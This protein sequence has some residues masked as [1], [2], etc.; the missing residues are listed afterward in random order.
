M[1]YSLWYDP[2]VHH[3]PKETIVSTPRRGDLSTTSYALLGLLAIQPW[4]TY[5]LAQHMG[6]SVGRLWPRAVSKLYEEPKKL[7]HHGL[8]TATAERVGRRPRTVYT[9]TPKG[10][11]ALRA[12]LAKPG[13][14]PSLE[15]EAL[16][17]VFFAENGTK[18]DTLA[19]L[20]SISAW[21]RADRAEHIDV[22]RVYAAGDGPFPQR[23]AML[24]LTGK[25]LVDFNEMVARW[26]AWAMSVVERWPDDPRMA[27]PERS[28]F[29]EVARMGDANALSGVA[30]SGGD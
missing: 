27:E 16:L 19:A 25:F 21:A 18:Q 29:E 5:E 6:R 14:G 9:I 10:R 7:V 28:V 15:F 4:T 1:I 13:K 22:A 30:A 8:A 20:A 23:A 17:K 3:S 24:A 11:R 2:D 26:A 12:W